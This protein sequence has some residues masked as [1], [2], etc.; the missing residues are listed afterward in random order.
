MTRPV[1]KSYY[2]SGQ[3][4]L[5][6]GTRNAT[7]GLGESFIA[8]GNVTSLTID[9]ATT[10]FEHKE[11]MSG[12]RSTDATIITEKKASCK[13]STESLSLDNLMLGLYGEQS[14][15]AGGAVVDEPH[16][17][18]AGGI[19]CLNSP[20]VS[21]VT[22][23]VGA[24]TAVLGTDYVLDAD[25]GTIHPLVGSTLFASDADVTVS[26]TA[27]AV[28]RVDAFT[29]TAQPERFLRFEGLNTYNG[30]LIL[31]E[32]P[33]VAIQPLTGLEYINDNFGKADFT[34]NILLDEKILTGS[35]FF[36]E[37]MITP[38]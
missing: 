26:Y 31:L 16:A 2:Y 3:G 19:I 20:K 5:L 38:A 4:R 27:A 22:V 15:T 6:I 30:D 28:K 34:G 10:V 23:K 9:V 13:F 24:T 14:V 1:P 37:Y 17:Y 11:S 32:A 8:V 25:F 18:V 7:T 35:Q 29:A 36:R 12:N 21:A 33:R